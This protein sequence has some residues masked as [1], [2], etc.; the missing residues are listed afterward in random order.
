MLLVFSGYR[1]PKIPLSITTDQLSRSGLKA[2]ENDSLGGQEPE[3]NNNK[4]GRCLLGH[5]ILNWKTV[6]HSERIMIP[7]R[8]F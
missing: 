8:I 5:T 6:Y 2:G 7:N 3:K 4:F 1:S